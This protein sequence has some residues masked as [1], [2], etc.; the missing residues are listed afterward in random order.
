MCISQRIPEYQ[1]AGFEVKTKK[2]CWVFN[3]TQQGHM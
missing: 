2:F 1:N 3:Y